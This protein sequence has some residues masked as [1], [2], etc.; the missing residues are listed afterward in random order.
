MIMIVPVYRV[1]SLPH[2][3]R[4]T[5]YLGK[6]GSLGLS[7]GYCHTPTTHGL[8]AGAQ[9]TPAPR[10]EAHLPKEAVCVE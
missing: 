1:V 3:A 4:C 5:R 8:L 6:T 10:C 2:P 9:T 7:F